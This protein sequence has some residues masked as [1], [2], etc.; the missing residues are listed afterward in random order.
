MYDEVE[1]YQYYN[2]YLHAEQFVIEPLSK[3]LKQYLKRGKVCK[4]FAFVLNTI[5]SFI[6]NSNGNENYI[7]L[8]CGIKWI[9]DD[10]ILI[11]SK[12]LSKLLGKT[13]STINSCFLFHGYETVK[14]NENASK[15]LI[16]V[17][18]ACINYAEAKKWSLKIKI[19]CHS[20]KGAPWNRKRNYIKLNREGDITI[21]E[22]DNKV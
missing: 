22:N 21:N 5:K 9:N 11:N 14:M 12:R 19:D 4:N 2:Y 6:M 3:Y 18:R 13:C 15:E 20:M 17:D 1:D 8:L 7:S 10:Q 16:E